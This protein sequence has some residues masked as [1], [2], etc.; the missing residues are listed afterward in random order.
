MFWFPVLF[1]DSCLFSSLCRFPRQVVYNF[2]V[3]WPELRAANLPAL[4]RTRASASLYA[5][6]IYDLATNIM[7]KCSGAQPG[8]SRCVSL[9]GR[10]P[11]WSPTG[12]VCW[13]KGQL[14]SF[15]TF[16]FFFFLT[17]I[18]L[19]NRAKLDPPKPR[20]AQSG[21][22]SRATSPTWRN[23]SRKKNI[24]PQTHYTHVVETFRRMGGSGK[25]IRGEGKPTLRGGSNNCQLTRLAPAFPTRSVLLSFGHFACA[26]ECT[27]SAM[28]R[29]D[30]PK[31]LKGARGSIGSRSTA[32]SC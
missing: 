25:K 18:T 14:E 23:P 15:F 17:V 22:T 28:R 21:A 2:A 3:S 8:T 30:P 13:S 24:I 26:P 32:S 7:W 11:P 6:S 16:S 12:V 20:A 27:D 29:G 10:F 19:P 31:F 5:I 9:R 1:A 4:S